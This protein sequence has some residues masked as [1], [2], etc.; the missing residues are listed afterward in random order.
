M[1]PSGRRSTT[2]NRVYGKT[3]S[4]VRIPSLPFMYYGVKKLKVI[5]VSSML[6][7]MVF[8]RE[9]MLEAF[10]NGSIFGKMA[11]TLVAN[12][13]ITLCKPKAAQTY[14]DLED[15]ATGTFKVEVRTLTK[16]GCL[17]IPSNQIG[18]GRSYNEEE[19]LKKLSLINGF[20]IVDIRTFPEL[21]LYWLDKNIVFEIFKTGIKNKKEYAIILNEGTSL[22]ENKKERVRQI[23]HETNSSFPT[24]IFD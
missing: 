13:Y 10:S 22:D 2:G 18:A 21:I 11:E 15:K 5:D 12:T 20:V 3:V 6:E 24:H 19:Y 1:C 16:S 4:G 9:Q 14:F 7:N 8:T 17:L 23:L